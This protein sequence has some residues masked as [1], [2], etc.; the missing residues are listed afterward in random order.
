MTPPRSFAEAVELRARRDPDGELIRRFGGPAVSA[1]ALLD[2]ALA[3]AGRLAALVGPGDTV[4]TAVPAGPEAAAL[5]TAISWLG[6]VELPVPDGLDPLLAGALAHATR[7]VTTVASPDRLDAEPH[8]ATLGQHTTHPV[9]TVEGRRAGIPSLEELPSRPTPGHRAELDAPSAVMV[10]SGTGGRPKGALLPNSSGL[11]QAERVRRAMDYDSHDV[12]FNVFPWQHIN[13]RHA[14]FLPAVLSGARV[15]VGPFSASRFW[16]TAADEQVT[17]F[18]FMGALCAM[19]LRQPASPDDH[20]HRVRQAYGGPA[21]DWLHQ[22][23]SE[24]FGVEL[25]QAYACTELGDVATTGREARPGWAGT[26]VPEY[27]VRVVDEHGV[28]VPDG[29]IGTVHVRPRRP[30]LTFTEYVGDA[31]ATAAAWRDGWFVTGDRGR[32]DDGW[33]S[34]EGR[35]ADVIRRRGVTID[36]ERVAQAALSYADVEEAAAVGV[37]SELTDDEVLLVVVTRPGVDLDPAELRRHCATRLPRHSV[38]RFVSVETSLPRTGS[39]KIVHRTLR[40]R[41]LPPSAWDA[42]APTP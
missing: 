41:G 24:R 2:R 23:V 3:T 16:T 21:P 34:H 38:P 14:A 27:D 9:T 22:Q 29:S 13:V 40:D 5:T 1:G 20:A 6:A 37:P 30:G 36:A 18:N 33:I 8:L 7:C 26:V 11:G 39:H 4:A 31:A 42:D 10:T 15:V 28:P 25:R 17:A 12:L 35:A 19:L 32:L